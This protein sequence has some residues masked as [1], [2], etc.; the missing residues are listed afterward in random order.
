M[1]IEADVFKQIIC[2]V[3]IRRAPLN[4]TI[5]ISNQL[6]KNIRTKKN[7]YVV[8]AYKRYDGEEIHIIVRENINRFS[9]IRQDMRMCLYG[10]HMDYNK[11]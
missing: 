1:S 6:W 10:K 2:K 9:I 7:I 3:K 8:I 11:T 5:L 4:M